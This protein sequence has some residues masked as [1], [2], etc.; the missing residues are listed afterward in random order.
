MMSNN[1]DHQESIN[2]FHWLLL[3]RLLYAFVFAAGYL[4]LIPLLY[5][6]PLYTKSWLIQIEIGVLHVLVAAIF[7]DFIK[8]SWIGFRTNLTLLY[9]GVDMFIT[10][11]IFLFNMGCLGI[12]LWAG[13][14]F[15]QPLALFVHFFGTLHT[16]LAEYVA[17]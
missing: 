3:Q 2:A 4:I 12:V 8:W 17:R 13:L 16:L 10:G 9:I 6:S 15:Q 7:Y 11:S 1:L 14:G 5:A